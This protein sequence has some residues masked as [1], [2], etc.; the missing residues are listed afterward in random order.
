LA[1]NK[2][3]GET[4]WQAKR[5]EI[6]SWSTPL[7]VEAAGKLQVVVSATHRVRSYELATGKLLWE[8]GGQTR[9][10]VASPVC[11]FGMVFAASGD[12]GHSLQ[13]IALGRSGDLTGSDAV[14]WHVNR[15]TPF[16]PSPLLY[17]NRLYVL[18]RNA[19]VLSCYQAETGTADY[20]Q[21]RLEGLGDIYAS[22]V[23]AADRVYVLDRDGTAVVI[24][25]SK[26]LEILATNTLDEAFDASPAIAGDE[27]FLRGKEHLY[28]ISR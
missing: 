14:K 18:S 23:G 9:N 1:V 28:C 20:E 17:G 19:A 12:A 2:R 10:V 27:I 26:N 25:R 8:C 13:A 6:S 11:G 7:V 24:K 5:N 15:G 21:A 22:P 16:V 4:I 3:T